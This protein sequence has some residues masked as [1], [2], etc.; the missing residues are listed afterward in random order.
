MIDKII[1]QPNNAEQPHNKFPNMYIGPR[2]MMPEIEEVFRGPPN[3]SSSAGQAQQIKEAELRCLGNALFFPGKTEGEIA[4]IIEQERAERLAPALEILRDEGI[5][6]Q[7]LSQRNLPAVDSVIKQFISLH[8]KPHVR[9][10]KVYLPKCFPPLTLTSKPPEINKFIQSLPCSPGGQNAYVR[11]LRAFFKWVYSPKSGLGL[12]YEDC[13]SPWIEHLRVPERIMPAQTEE[14]FAKLLSYV[15]KTHYLRDVTILAVFIDSGGRRAEVANIR[16]PDILWAQR[17]IRA[18][19]K[20]DREIF[21]PFSEE[22]EALLR[23]WVQEYHP[24]P[25]E[26][27]WGLTENGIVSMLRRLE[28]KS[29]IKCNAHTFRRGFASILCKKN[30]NSVIIKNLGHWKSTRMV[31]DLYT[32]SVTFEDSQKHYQAPMKSIA[33][34]QSAALPTELPR[35]K[36]YSSD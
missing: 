9:F 23:A 12:R 32:K 11:V 15:P 1:A 29:G 7:V 18:I 28:K 4:Q 22:T 3:A 33:N 26:N 24:G 34:F 19:A 14:S 20:G 17:K 2:R 31:D 13:P 16:E 35:R 8:E 21:M 5:N 30:L 25:N 10:Y 27:I 6:L 36:V